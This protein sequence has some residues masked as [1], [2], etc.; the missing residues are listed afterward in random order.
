[1]RRQTPMPSKSAQQHRFMEAAAHNPA[2]AEKAG[3]PQNVA[4]EFVAADKKAAKRTPSK[5][6]GKKRKS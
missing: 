3:I 1:M 5:R 2:F 6:S 4:K